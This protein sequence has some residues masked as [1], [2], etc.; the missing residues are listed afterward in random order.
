MKRTKLLP[1][2]LNCEDNEGRYDIIHP[3]NVER[4]L[5]MFMT[6]FCEKEDLVA[7]LAFIRRVWV[8]IFFGRIE[9]IMGNGRRVIPSAI[10]TAGIILPM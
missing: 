8:R 9:W 10:P 2:M 5:Q 6:V 1:T 7:F 3:E 4:K